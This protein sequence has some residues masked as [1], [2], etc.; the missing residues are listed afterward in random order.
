MVSAALVEL[1]QAFVSR[2]GQG[3]PLDVAER[4]T[5]LGSPAWL[6]SVAIVRPRSATIG[7][8]ALRL[9]HAA[10]VPGHALPHCVGYVELGAALFGG[11][12]AS[13]AIEASHRPA[14]QRRRPH[15]PHAVRRAPPR[16]PDHRHVGAA[17]ARLARRGR[18]RPGQ[19]R[20]ARRWQPPP[21]G[22][23]ACATAPG[24][25]PPPGT[26]SCPPPGARRWPATSSRSATTA[27]HAAHAPHP[28]PV[29]RSSGPGRIA[30][31]T[32]GTGA[33]WGWTR[34][35]LTLPAGGA[36]ALAAGTESERGP[37][38]RRGAV[39]SAAHGVVAGLARGRRRR[40]PAAVLPG[41][42]LRRRGLGADRRARPLAVDAG[43]RRLGRADPGPV[44]VRRPRP[45]RRT[46]VVADVRGPVLPGRRLARRQLPGR[47][48]GLLLPP[49]L[50]G[51]R[52][53]AGPL[54]PRAGRGGHLLR[55]SGTRPRKRNL[56]G[57]FQTGDYADPDGEPRRHLAAGAGDR[58]G[59]GPHRPPAALCRRA[60][61]ERAASCSG[62]RSTATTPARCGC[63]PS[64]AAPTTRSTSRWPPGPTTVEWRSWS[65][66]PTLWW[67]RALGDPP[68][69][70]YGW[71]CDPASRRPDGAR[72]VGRRPQRRGRP[73]PASD[74]RRLRT[75]LRGPPAAL[76]AVGQRRA[77]V[78]QGAEPGP[79]PAGARRGHAR[80]GAGRRRPRGGA[81]LDLVRL[82]GHVGRPETYD[83]A[84]EAGLLVW[85]DMPLRGPYARAVRR[86]AA[87]RPPSWWPCSATT[88][89][90]RCG[91]A[92]TSRSRS[93][94]GRRRPRPGPPCATSWRPAA[95][96]LE[97]HVPRLARS[98]GRSTGPTAPGRSSPTRACCPT[99]RS[100]TAPTPTSTPAG[101]G[102]TSATS[103]G[104]ARALPRLV[105]FVSRVRRPGRA[106][107]R[108]RRVL[109]A[110]ALARPRLGPP[111]GRRT[112]SSASGSTA[113]C[114]PATTHLRRLARRHPALPGRADPPAGRD[115]A[116][117]QVP[118][119]RRVRPSPCWP[120]PGR[121]CPWRCSTT[122]GGPS[123]PTRRCGRPAGR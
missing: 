56:T 102:A 7:A 15:R 8:D 91:A 3:T 65:S 105:R 69:S 20:P 45:R 17:A 50:R 59:P 36:P 58:D 71:P 67:P 25:C 103:A 86:Q 77:A 54:G 79:R 83:A 38:R 46:A 31:G 64:W 11:R 41:R 100:S 104:L 39:A 32:S 24:P 88:R 33:T 119:D 94:T 95:A 121:R 112:A 48:R 116:A 98:S 26:P 66:A 70:T 84:D 122:S 75:G 5:G 117:A 22:S 27:F 81:G 60:D 63:G 47:H 12:D 53:P 35:R 30:A 28:A 14:R 68:C 4:L 120:T 37:E 82:H 52:R 34:R 21:A 61:A 85:Q 16:R 96:Q 6:L 74:E 1:A 118:A 76:G 115:A 92:T 44:P 90:W 13:D 123:R 10:G 78:P 40:R 9:A 62:R 108:R 2:Q 99:R 19:P 42:R 29:G 113:T 57:A 18:H 114:R 49:H 43:L 109:R 110:R 97:P 107:G 87:A 23:S 51:D 89:R 111:G 101:T 55:P 93:P 72:R 106:L 80:R 73:A